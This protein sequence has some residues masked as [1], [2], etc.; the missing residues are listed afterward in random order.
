MK[1][2]DFTSDQSGKFSTGFYD[3][4]K[5][6]QRG[7]IFYVYES[8]KKEAEDMTILQ[9]YK[10]AKKIENKFSN[11]N[12]NE[13]EKLILQGIFKKFIYA[14]DVD[15]PVLDQSYDPLNLHHIPNLLDN[16]VSKYAHADG[17]TT[18]L[19]YIGAMGSRF[20]WHVEDMNLFS[21]SLMLFG[22][23]KIWYSIPEHRGM[24]L[25]KL[26]EKYKEWPSLQ[27][28][29]PLRHKNNCFDPHFVLLSG[30]E[31]YKVVC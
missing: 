30:I 26:Q 12:I 20:G 13:K 29:S 1:N 31:V 7:G 24:D 18:P 4:L 11:L 25:E 15:F 19:S 9:Y 5:S 27:C 22:E 28:S 16:Y 2:F 21:I 10:Q 6:E 17:I 3:V 23:P 14:T 8:A